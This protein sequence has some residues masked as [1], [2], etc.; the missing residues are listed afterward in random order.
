MFGLITRKDLLIHPTTL[1]RGYGWRV[2]GS[3]S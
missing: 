3:G 1:C 2:L